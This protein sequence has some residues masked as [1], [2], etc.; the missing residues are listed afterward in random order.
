MNE[1]IYM[2]VAYAVLI[3]TFSF[4]GILR[5]CNL[6][7]HAI[8][9]MEDIYPA[10]RLVVGI[11][12]SVLLLFPCMLYPQSHDAQ[13]LARC[14]WI[15]YIPLSA[16]LAFRRFFHTDRCMNRK[17]YTM[18]CAIPVMAV[19][20]LFAFAVAGGGSLLQHKDI[21]VNSVEIIS[22]A[23]TAYLIRVTLG[24]WNL[25]HA[26]REETVASP[27]SVPLHF[28]LGIFWLP[29]V[30]Q[31]LAWGVHLYDS[32]FASVTL[33]AATAVMGAVILVAILRPQRIVNNNTYL[34]EPCYSDCDEDMDDEENTDDEEDLDGD[35][36]MEMAT[37]LPVST[38]DRIEQQVRDAVEHDQM[39][40]NPNLTKA[41]LVSQLGINNLYLHIV[42]KERFGTFNKYINTLRME[43]AM[44]YENEHPEVKCEEL[45]LKSG[46][47]SVRTY[48]RAKKQYEVDCSD[49]QTVTKS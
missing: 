43:Y 47:G 28:A 8:K 3:F 23:L 1:Y 9:N 46:F 22:I 35:E 44:R 48:Y 13:L 31:I 20:I 21:V 25:I 6:F 14:F 40:L 30:A 18:V 24:V 29:L 39:Y 19:L 41:T 42:I 38:I 45:A 15:I 26:H 16:S 36:D 4:C 2:T 11:Y 27:S 34:A 5:L 17:E 7:P 32:A 10:R 37:K 33:A 12:F 49:G